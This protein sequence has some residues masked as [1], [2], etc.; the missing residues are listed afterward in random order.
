MASIEICLQAALF[1]N[2]IT[3]VKTSNVELNIS[4]SS[5][6]ISVENIAKEP[7]SNHL[8]TIKDASDVG[9]GSRY[10]LSEEQCVFIL[11]IAC[12][13]NQTNIFFQP[14]GFKYLPTKILENPEDRPRLEDESTETSDGKFVKIAEYGTIKEGLGILIKQ[15]MSLKETQILEIAEK[16]LRSR[17][18]ESNKPTLLES[19]ISV[20]IKRYKG[21]L[22][23]I[24]E[25]SS[26]KSLYDAFE[27]VV[28]ADNHTQGQAFD[29]KASVLTGMTEGEIKDLRNFN[30]RLKH[31]L[32]NQNHLITFMAGEKEFTALA[33]NLKKAADKAI[34][35]RL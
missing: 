26:Y 25:L 30:N 14:V 18:F 4:D 19:N 27:I 17:I 10:N 28:N 6:K 32:T 1:E 22:T 2:P 3:Y 31:V 11:S 16:L 8:F 5:G 7:R 15:E 24:E 9:Y 20:A 35:S 13:L 23:S 33:I 12:S 34:L 29:T 21:V